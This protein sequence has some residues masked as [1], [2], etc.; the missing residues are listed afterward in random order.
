MSFNS[1]RV[2]RHVDHLAQE[3]LALILKHLNTAEDY[4]ISLVKRKPKTFFLRKLRSY[5]NGRIYMFFTVIF[6]IVLNIVVVY[7]KNE[8]LALRV[9]TA[10][11]NNVTISNANITLPSNSSIIAQCYQQAGFSDVDEFNM[12]QDLFYSLS[13]TY[14]TLLSILLFSTVIRLMTKIQWDIFYDIAILAIDLGL[15]IDGL[16]YGGNINYVGVVL[17]LRIILFVADLDKLQPMLYRLSIFTPKILILIVLFMG[18]LYISALF[19]F[20]FYNPYVNIG[21]SSCATYFADTKTTFITLYT[22][23]TFQNWVDVVAAMANEPSLNPAIA[24]IYIGMLSVIMN[25]VIFNVFLAVVVDIVNDDSLPVPNDVSDA[26]WNRVLETFVDELL[27]M[28]L[29]KESRKKIKS[30]ELS[31]FLQ[32]TITII[33]LV[34]Q[35][36]VLYVKIGF[37]LLLPIIFLISYLQ[38]LH[39]S[40]EKNNVTTVS[41]LD[42]QQLTEYNKIAPPKSSLAWFFD[43]G[44]ETD[45]AD[46][47]VETKEKNTQDAILKIVQSMNDRMIDMNQRIMN[48]ESQLKQMDAKI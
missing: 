32:L 7:A 26:F 23:S 13:V 22:V 40:D 35:I 41:P 36:L 38:N 10:C 25:F 47:K 12:H 17:P 27:I 6:T 2:F 34:I 16:L 21:C 33:A 30:E 3:S 1:E 43:E 28:F 46:A 29:D 4:I 31:S 44:S 19:T 8:P 42:E 11:V 5:F 18:V 14:I 48:M 39:K 9:A 15:S 20:F 45:A 24:Q 37:I